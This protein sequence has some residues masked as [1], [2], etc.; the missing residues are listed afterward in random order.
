MSEDILKEIRLSEKEMG[1]R[2]T[3]AEEQAGQ[4][5]RDAEASAR[6]A[7]EEQVQALKEY[8]QRQLRIFEEEIT[9]KSRE[10]NELTRNRVKDLRKKASEKSGAAVEF[11]YQEILKEVF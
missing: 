9:G 1:R 8:E 2:R 11:I 4:I 7:I 3:Q 5:L 6:R 10:K